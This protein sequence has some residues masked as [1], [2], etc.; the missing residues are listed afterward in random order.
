MAS[1][2]AMFLYSL[3]KKGDHSAAYH[4]KYVMYHELG[5]GETAQ[6]WKLLALQTQEPEFTPELT[7]KKPG[8]VTHICKPS[9]RK[10]ETDGSLQLAGQPA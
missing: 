2:S 8:V 10:V 1:A 5:A 4:N 3:A 7:L 9:T 6:P